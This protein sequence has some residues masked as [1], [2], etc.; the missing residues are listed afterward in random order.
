MQLAKTCCSPRPNRAS[1][2]SRNV[3]GSEPAIAAMDYMKNYAEQVRAFIPAESY[4]VLGTDGFGRSDSRENLRT[5]FEI[6]RHYVVSRPQRI[7]QARRR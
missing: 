2:T 4:A 1:R 5:H 6:N 7:G 3:M